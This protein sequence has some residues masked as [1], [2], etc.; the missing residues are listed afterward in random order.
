MKLKDAQFITSATSVNAFPRVGLP[1]IA[2]IGRSNVGKSSL[3][4]S[5]LQRKK[6]A[7]TS[8]SPGRTRVINFFDVDG[9]F[10]FV[11]LPGYGFAKVPGKVRTGWQSMIEG[12]F[13]SRKELVLTLLLI[14]SRHNPMKNDIAMKEWMEYQEIPFI[15][16]FTKADKLAGGKLKTQVTQGRKLMQLNSTVRSVPYSCVTGE[17]RRDLLKILM[18]KTAQ[19]AG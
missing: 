3:I 19:P 17:G 4:N 16:V 12:Y 8:K 2:F 15:V 13:L 7:L 18:E 9:K 11:D 6:L 14:D 1:E 5:L 10:I